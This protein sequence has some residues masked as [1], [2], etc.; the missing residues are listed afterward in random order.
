[1][2]YFIVTF[3]VKLPYT[4]QQYF[5]STGVRREKYICQR[6]FCLQVAMRENVS[7]DD[8]LITNIIEL[9]ENDFITFTSNL[10]P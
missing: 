4:L 9:N 10:M 7:Y 8:V 3:A 6:D 5:G 1:M 2:R